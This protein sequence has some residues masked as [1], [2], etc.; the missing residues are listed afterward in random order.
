MPILLNAITNNTFIQAEEVIIYIINM[1]LHKPIIKFG[2]LKCIISIWCMWIIL[3]A[4]LYKLV[5]LLLIKYF[6][7]FFRWSQKS[8]S[9]CRRQKQ[10]YC[11]AWQSSSQWQLFPQYFTQRTQK[12]LCLSAPKVRK[13]TFQYH[14]LYALAF[15]TRSKNNREETVIS[16]EQIL[17][18]R[19]TVV[20][21]LKI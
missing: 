7:F 5:I 12:V 2:K 4:T 19:I 3:R 6:Y 1:L 8:K 11:Q 15:I 13:L 9:P 16:F 17:I 20:D 10:I 18:S 21:Y 14:T